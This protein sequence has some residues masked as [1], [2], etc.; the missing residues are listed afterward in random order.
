MRTV[1]LCAGKEQSVLAHGPRDYWP[2]NV[3][4][5]VSSM[6]GQELSLLRV[7][8]SQKTQ[9]HVLGALSHFAPDLLDL[10]DRV[11]QIFCWAR[12]LGYPTPGNHGTLHEAVFH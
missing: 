2:F 3:V 8:H 1:Q 11:V 9:E 7:P 4:V 10:I 5:N 12:V 6:C